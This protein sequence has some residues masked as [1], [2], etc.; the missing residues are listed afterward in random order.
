MDI[1]CWKPS[2]ASAMTV[3]GFAMKKKKKKKKKGTLERK[4]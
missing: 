2:N 1:D 4:Q 3:R